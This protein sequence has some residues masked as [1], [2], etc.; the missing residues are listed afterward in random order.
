MHIQSDIDLEIM[1]RLEAS[2]S[3]TPSL[4]GSFQCMGT[5]GMIASVFF[6]KYPLVM[7]NIAIENGYL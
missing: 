4:A 6:N 7:T 2:C 1:S 5:E 3:P